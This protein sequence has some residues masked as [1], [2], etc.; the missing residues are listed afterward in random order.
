MAPRWPESA[1]WVV[2]P[3]SATADWALAAAVLA[4]ASSGRVAVIAVGVTGPPPEPLLAHVAAWGELHDGAT[5]PLRL[6]DA[7]RVTDAFTGTHD[8]VL[9]VGAAGLTAPAGRLGW[10]TADLA[11]A[12][13]APGVVVVGD[14]PRGVNY[15]TVEALESRGLASAL[16]TIGTAPARLP[17][18]P[19]GRI[20]AGL[21]ALDPETARGFLDAHLRS[22]PA[23]PRPTAGHSGAAR[24]E[25]GNPGSAPRSASARPGAGRSGREDAVPA[26]GAPAPWPERGQWMVLPVPAG[27]DWEPAITAL[28]AA[29]TARVAV[30]A[31][32]VAGPP[33]ARP[34]AHL[35]TWIGLREGRQQPL[36]RAD[37]VRVSDALA[38]THGVV[39]VVGAAEPAGWPLTDLA[40]ALGAPVVLVTA[41][42]PATATGAVT[43]EPPGAAAGAVTAEAAA[44]TAAAVA[45]EQPARA[46]ADESGAGPADDRLA[47]VRRAIEEHGL[48][49]AVI[50]VG[51][52]VLAE[53]PA[54][55]VPADA[56][57]LTAEAARDLL[58]P[59]LHATR[60][61]VP[62]PVPV[63]RRR[64]AAPRT[65][66]PRTAA[67]RTARPAAPP[68]TRATGTR[69]VLML[70][71]IFVVMSL[72]V[73]G[74]AFCNRTVAP[75]SGAASG[76]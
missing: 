36:R 16:V 31:I 52:V 37:A 43:P 64:P 44:T 17:A 29:S 32:G 39:L 40:T 28:A 51:D 58:H 23:L 76:R 7:L 6:A 41:D 3:T 12:L 56:G 50:A 18:A 55:R 33:A 67:A 53:P 35:A 5:E 72:S 2:V 49:S 48:A 54:G 69:I 61:A 45:G 1:T 47:A 46:A 13:G 74:L 73:V 27:V 38:R 66:A 14:D 19:A 30:V 22:G 8:L 65:A 4:A 70:I 26:R 25:A 62:P 57:D 63:R 11:A 24:P 42:P 15:T 10:T 21:R 9:I 59:M 71:S 60:A 75:E 34:A 20:P 68:G